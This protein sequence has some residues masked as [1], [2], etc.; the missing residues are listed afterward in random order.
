MSPK[1][2]PLVPAESLGPAS[3]P[4]QEGALVADP[5]QGLS[6]CRAE[7]PGP[8]L[9]GAVGSFG[10]PQRALLPKA[11]SSGCCWWQ[12]VALD[13]CGLSAA[14]LTSTEM[15]FQFLCGHQGQSKNFRLNLDLPR[16][17]NNCGPQTWSQIPGLPFT[18]P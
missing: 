18:Q 8:S 6:L 17:T 10:H 3:A 15:G 11:P 13:F 4:Q 9:S 2:K 16:R 14:F 5:S 7:A 12:M 1:R